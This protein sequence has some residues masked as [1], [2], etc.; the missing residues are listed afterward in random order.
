MLAEDKTLN[1]RDR[2]L[3]QQLNRELGELKER[4][5]ALERKIDTYLQE[6]REL[7]RRVDDLE[8]FRYGV[9]AVIAVVA[10]IVT[11]LGGLVMWVLSW[12]KK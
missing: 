3:I 1:E 2:R 6:Q 9:S 4:I 7:E 10:F 8:R 5:H 12:V 11:T